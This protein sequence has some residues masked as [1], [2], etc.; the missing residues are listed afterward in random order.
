MLVVRAAAPV[1]SLLLAPSQKTTQV[2]GGLEVRLVSTNSWLSARESAIDWVTR[3][4]G[5]EGC[6]YGSIF[7]TLERSSDHVLEGACRAR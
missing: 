4:G 2:S 6:L 7:S 1:P 5:D 3:S